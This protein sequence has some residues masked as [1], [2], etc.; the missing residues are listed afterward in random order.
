MKEFKP[1][2]MG[3]EDFKVIIDKGSYYV[4]KTNMIRELLDSGAAVED[5]VYDAIK[6]VTWDWMNVSTNDSSEATREVFKW[7]S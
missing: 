3:V 4:D 6:N 5:G 2:P 1:L 7:V